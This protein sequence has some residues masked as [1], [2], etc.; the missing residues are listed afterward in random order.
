MAQSTPWPV[1]YW[2]KVTYDG[3]EFDG[4]PC[5]PWVASRDRQGYGRFV[6]VRAPEMAYR[7]AY[8]LLV[9]P[10]PDG[11]VIDH[12]CRNPPCVNPAHLEPVTRQENFRRGLHRGRSSGKTHCDNGHE[13]TAENTYEWRGTRQCREC[14]RLRNPY[15]DRK[16]AYCRQR[17]QQRKAAA[18]V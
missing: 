13:F 14:R 18:Q 1:R 8:E 6:R 9:G 15:D 17:Y 4:E 11:L 2:A 16:R 12:L 3:P 7:I 10:I 5:W